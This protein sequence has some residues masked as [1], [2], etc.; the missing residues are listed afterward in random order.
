M[1]KAIIFDCFGVLYP[2][3]SG[4][5]FDKYKD[6]FDS[7][8]GIIDD[9]NLQIDLGKINRTQFFEGLEKVTKIPALSIKDEFDSEQ[10]SPD[11][12][13]VDIIKKLKT[14]YK[15]ALLSNAGEEEIGIIYRDKVAALFE[16]KTISYDVGF[17]KPSE[18]IYLECLKNLGVEPNDALF[19]DDS[20]INIEAARKLGIQT[21]VYP[22]FGVIPQDLQQLV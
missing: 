10:H 20:M 12:K 5:F 8:P 2:H 4:N 14:K 13:L 7:N 17:V 18:E 6:L 21:L 1:I 9:L 16:V 11:L 22:D 3:S 15:I 19:V